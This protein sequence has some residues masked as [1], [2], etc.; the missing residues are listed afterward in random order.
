L[1]VDPVQGV[2]GR[3]PA[4]T[5]ARCPCHSSNWGRFCERHDTIPRGLPGYHLARAN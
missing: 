3:P 2:T 5:R 4:K 1:F